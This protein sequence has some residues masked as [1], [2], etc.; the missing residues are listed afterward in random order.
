M[1]VMN[2]KW[3]EAA[4]HKWQRRILGITWRDKIRN[5]EIRWRTGMET[6]EVIL[7]KIRLQWLRHVH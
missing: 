3:L 2:M 4:H 5:E 7:R 1:T 6:M